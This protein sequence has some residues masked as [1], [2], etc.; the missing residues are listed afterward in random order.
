VVAPKT[1]NKR[2]EEEK[3]QKL[4]ETK[5]KPT[6]PITKHRELYDGI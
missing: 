3:K 6:Q 2:P 5:T 4:H 1:T